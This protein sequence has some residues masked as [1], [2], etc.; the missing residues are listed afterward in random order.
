MSK[1]APIA[2]AAVSASNLRP[3]GSHCAVPIVGGS[4]RHMEDDDS[5]QMAQDDALEEEQA[6][7]EELAKLQNCL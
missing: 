6:I 2:A 1:K 7:L 5:A 3:E 4:Q